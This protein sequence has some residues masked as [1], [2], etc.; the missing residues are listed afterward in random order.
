MKSFRD[1]EIFCRNT[2]DAN[3]PYWHLYTQG[4][5]TPLIFKKKDDYVFA[6]NIVCQAACEFP[7][8]KIITF[9][10]MGN[11]LHF[12]LNGEREVAQAFFTF[13]RKR[14]ALGLRESFPDGLPGTFTASIKPVED[15]NSLR[16][17]IVYINRNGFVADQTQTPYSYPWG[18]GRYYFNEF[19]I[20]QEFKDLKD[21]E[22]RQMFRARKPPIPEACKIID[23]Y[24]APS[25]YCSIKLGMAFFRHAHHYISLL[26]RNV[27]AYGEIAMELG[28]NE[29]CTD[30]EL[31]SQLSRIIQ[32]RYNLATSK[33]LTKAQKTDL[34]RTLRNTYRSSNSQISRVLGLSLYEVDAM[35]PLT[36]KRSG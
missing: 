17:T 18:A 11:H 22:V 21:R 32:S 24:I 27:E 19:P 12:L 15:I 36:A 30:N 16:N 8:T 31:Y 2:F 28:D 29:A 33:D 25:S 7:Q 13:I 10:I 4:H 6:M 5:D 26:F 3:G 20:L 34:A 1:G 14:L 23:G 35:F 9:E